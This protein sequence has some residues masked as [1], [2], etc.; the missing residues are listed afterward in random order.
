MSLLLFRA[1]VDRA[2]VGRR[3]DRAGTRCAGMTIE[4]SRR[5]RMDRA[6]RP[7]RELRPRL[8]VLESIAPPS[9]AAGT[10]T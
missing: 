1:L 6:A 8:E 2:D 10:G 4:F 9:G 7:R 5:M 3:V